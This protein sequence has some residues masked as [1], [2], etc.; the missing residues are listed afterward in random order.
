MPR[1]M[2]IARTVLVAMLVMAPAAV[3][4]QTAPSLVAAPGLV[5]LPGDAPSPA[6]RAHALE[7]AQL[8]NNE[9]T[10]QVQTSRMLRFALSP[11]GRKLSTL[12]ADVRT[13]AA[14]WANHRDPATEAEV[15]KAVTALVARR[16]AGKKEARK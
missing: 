11:V 10:L 1:P 13:L 14:S 6:L 9:T 7:L 3:T 15:T 12:N 2:T 8:L 4:A 5:P 16:M